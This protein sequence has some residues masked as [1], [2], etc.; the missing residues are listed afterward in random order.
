[1]QA[2]RQS[3]Q[4]LQADLSE[5]RVAYE[6]GDAGPEVSAAGDGIGH[7]QQRE[8]EE[9]R[10]QNAMLQEAMQVRMHA[11][12]PISAVRCRG[13]I[14]SSSHSDQCALNE[15]GILEEQFLVAPVCILNSCIWVCH[16]KCV[17]QIMPHRNRAPQKSCL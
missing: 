2:A 15:Q 11:D 7:V 16:C 12:L 3:E 10:T 1:M 13:G 5:A 9:L 6:N 14:P 8:M 17:S 4:R